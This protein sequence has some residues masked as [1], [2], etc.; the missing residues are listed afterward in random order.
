MPAFLL[1]TKSS[2]NVADSPKSEERAF[3]ESSMVRKTKHVMSKKL[4]ILSMVATV[5]GL[6]FVTNIINVQN[7]VAFYVALPLGAIFLGLSLMFR[8]FEN[9]MLAYDQ[10]HQRHP[11]VLAGPKADCCPREAHGVHA[12]AH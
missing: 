1:F 9:E 3:G 8:S 11:A 7:A 5:A 10:E 12:V 2:K 4:F 6:A